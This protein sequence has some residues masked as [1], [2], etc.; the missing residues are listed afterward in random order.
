MRLPKFLAPAEKKKPSP[1]LNAY[2]G[3]TQDLHYRRTSEH[4]GVQ[5]EL[6]LFDA[7]GL[8]REVVF[9]FD[10]ESDASAGFSKRVLSYRADATVESD[11]Y[12]FSPAYAE[13]SGD[14]M[15]ENRYAPDGVSLAERRFLSSD[16]K[17][18]EHG[19]LSVVVRYENGAQRET[20]TSYDPASP[21]YDGIARTVQRFDERG[22]RAACA[23]I[24]FDDELA[25]QGG[26]VRQVAWFKEDATT[27]ERFDRYYTEG[28]A[29]ELGRTRDTLTMEEDDVAS[30]EY[31]PMEMDEGSPF[32]HA[33]ERY[34][35]GRIFA[36]ELYAD[37]P[38]MERF[39]VSLYIEYFDR[40]GAVERTETIL[41]RGE[42]RRLGYDRVVR[43]F[44]PYSDSEDPV[45]VTRYKGSKAVPESA[46][47]AGADGESEGADDP[48][49][50]VGG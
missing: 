28:K 3:E 11:L 29:Q 26:I 23:E 18:I 27:V 9:I 24:A 39:G 12:F 43:E 8:L 14:A 30:I 19:I 1:S 31:D 21:A 17:R 38:R 33:V 50:D 44:D 36:R 47:G 4:D 37:P 41:P 5:R 13:Q 42:A 10:A 6:R 49:L 40:D 16:R 25:A 32:I 7:A 15:I 34:E 48:A 2:G 45:S 20:E 35:D 46:E 22:E